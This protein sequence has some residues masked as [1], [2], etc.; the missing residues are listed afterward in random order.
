MENFVFCAVSEDLAVHNDKQKLSFWNLFK[1]TSF[2]GRKLM[3]L[4]T[5]EIMT[6][7]LTSLFPHLL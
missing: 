6:T 2:R 1:E 5:D 7:H 3:K 4:K